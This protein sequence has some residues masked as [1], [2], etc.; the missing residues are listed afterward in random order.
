MVLAGHVPAEPPNG[1]R[2]ARRGFIAGGFIAGG[3]SEAVEVHR[4]GLDEA[5]ELLMRLRRNPG[6]RASMGAAARQTVEAVYSRE[7]RERLAA[8]YTS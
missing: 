4:R 8:F 2:P 1:E 7:R 3:R 5:A 6:L